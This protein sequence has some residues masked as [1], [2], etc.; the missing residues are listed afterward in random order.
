MKQFAFPV[1]FTSLDAATALY[2]ERDFVWIDSNRDTHPQNRFSYIACNPLEKSCVLPTQD[3][4]P[5][6]QGG[7][8][9]YKTYEGEG[10]FKFYDQI[11]AFDHRTGERWLI[12]Y[13]DNERDAHK[14]YDDICTKVRTAKPLSA[15]H[16]IQPEWVSNFTE[17]EYEDAVR[18]IIARILNGDIFQANLTQRFCA[19][20][21][22][23]FN[24]FFHYLILREINP[25]PFSAYLHFG[26]VEILSA[27]PESFLSVTKAGHIVTQ[28]IKGTDTDAERL[29]A[30]VKDRAENTMIVDLLRNDLSQICTDESVI[31]EKLCELQSFAGLHHLVSKIS[32]QLQKDITPI[33]AVDACFPGGSITGAPKIEAMKIIAEIEKM[34]RDIYCGSIGWIGMDGAMEMNIAIRTLVADKDTLSFGVGGGITALS[35][36][37][38]EY[39][40]TLLKAQKIFK[41]FEGGNK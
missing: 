40:E 9:G 3:G 24:G 33:K 34:P 41:S 10:H 13:A 18:D 32:G 15:Y 38:A 16:P 27:S 36:P 25:A 12:I 6:F 8:M 2:S 11:L 31:V 21:P 26:D 7:Y 29:L 28:P 35:D 17:C 4:L 20:K 30:S 22:A 23:N 37:E 5:P 19:A 14:A 1:G 39:Q